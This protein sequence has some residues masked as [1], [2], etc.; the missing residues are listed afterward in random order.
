MQDLVFFEPTV[1]GL[2]KCRRDLTADNFIKSMETVKD[3]KGIGVKITS[4]PNKRPGSRSEFLAR[5]AEG[6]R[7]HV[8]PTRKS[9]TLMYRK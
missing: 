3:F 7:L 1:E 9:L 6:G 5:C 8:F 2:K 4:G